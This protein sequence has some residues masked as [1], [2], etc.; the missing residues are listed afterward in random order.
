MP[1]QTSPIPPVAI[2]GVEG[3]ATGVVHEVLGVRSLSL[4][5]RLHHALRDRAG[6]QAA[7]DLAAG[8][9]AFWIMI[10]TATCGSSAGAKDTNQAYGGTS[11]MPLC[12]VP[13]L[14]ATSTPGWPPGSPCPRRRCRSSAR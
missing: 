12:A 1:R 7:G 5:D 10:A 8:M 3:V 11:G 14:P 4:I 9:L 13:V 6:E 2:R